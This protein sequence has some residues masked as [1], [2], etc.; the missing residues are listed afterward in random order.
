MADATRVQALQ[1][2]ATFTPDA[3]MSRE[4]RDRLTGL[5]PLDVRVKYFAAIGQGDFALVHAVEQAPQAFALIDADTREQGD[6]MKLG[7]HPL[8]ATL[9]AQ[10]LAARRHASVVA[11][12]RTELARLAKQFGLPDVED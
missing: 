7:R 10:A 1:P 12:T 4:I 5:D 3:A 9:D 6:A 11:T 2:P 8:K